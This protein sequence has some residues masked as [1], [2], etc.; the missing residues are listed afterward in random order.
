MG[1]SHR[2]C[3]RGFVVLAAA[4]GLACSSESS[5]ATDAGA[6]GFPAGDS[7]T[8]ANGGIAGTGAA[9]S[10]GGSTAG[11]TDGGGAGGT[12]AGGGSGGTGGASGPC[13]TDAMCDDGIFC[14]GTESCTS[15]ACQSGP[16]PCAG[17]VCDESGDVCQASTGAVITLDVATK[18]QTM[19]G[20]EATAQAGQDPID[21]GGANFA[22]FKDEVFDRAVELGINRLRVE[23]RSGAENTT[24]HWSQL[25]A[26]TITTAQWKPLRYPIVNDDA[27]AFHIEPTGFHFSQLDSVVNLIVLPMKQRV[28]ALGEKLFINVNYVSFLAAA[29]SLHASDPEEY[30]EFA[31]ATVQHLDTTFGIVPDTWEVILEPD[32]VT[33]WTGP[34]IGAAIARTAARFASSGYGSIK[35]VAPSNTNMTNAV[36]YFD[37]LIQVTGVAGTLSELSYH[38]YGGVS[39]ASLQAIGQRAATYGIGTSM[40]EHIGSG[41]DDLYADLTTG[42]NSA[43]Q[44]FTLAYPGTA[45][46]DGGKYFGV[47]N[48]TTLTPTVVMMSRTRLLRQYFKFVRAGAVRFGAT[49]TSGTFQPVAFTNVGGSVVVPVKAS[50]AGSFDVDGLPAGTYGIKYTT[51]TDYD[52]NLPDQTVFSGQ[53]LST[54]IPAAG[55]VTIYGK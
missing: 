48:P 33:V 25:Q 45:V 15:S 21:T 14:N 50:A 5:R 54:S 9:A 1:G 39:T 29:A 35:F 17:Q 40:L 3:S 36:T 11:G 53:R 10:T 23:I 6:G 20:W 31:L 46:D 41:V 28:E 8:G 55:V 51:A 27:D 43:W 19:T 38:R 26:G 30:A 2:F 22:A 7:S 16:S 49:S 24:D 44:Q 12:G 37:Q 4:T 47:E 18:Y 32:N 52:M 13:T 34:T 42:M